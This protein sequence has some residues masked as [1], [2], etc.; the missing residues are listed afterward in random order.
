MVNVTMQDNMDTYLDILHDFEIKKR[1]ITDNLVTLKLPPDVF[2]LIDKNMSSFEEAV[3]R[4]GFQNSKV[5]RIQ[6]IISN[7]IV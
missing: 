2:R 6:S 7:G 5:D 1:A 4:C 3:S